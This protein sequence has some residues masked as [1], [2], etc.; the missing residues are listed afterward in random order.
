MHF[1]TFHAARMVC[2][3]GFIGASACAP[4]AFASMTLYG[5]VDSFLQYSNNSGDTAWRLQSGGASTSRWGI[6]GS[7]DLGGG[8]YS[9][10][11]LE[12]GIN[13]MNGQQQSATSIY[14]R[15]AN[16]WLGAQRFGTIKLGKQYPAIPPEGAD[17]FYAVGMLSPW[18][19]SVLAVSDLGPGAATVQARTDNAISYETPIWSGFSAKVLYALRNAAGASPVARNAGGIVN[20]ANGPLAFNVAYNAVWTDTP[21]GPAASTPDGPRTDI[22]MADVLYDFGALAASATYT[23]T[24]PT[25]PNTY[26]AAV[27]SLGAVWTH[28]PHVIRAGAVYRNVAGRE[29]SAFGALV[30]YDYQFSKLTGVYARVGGFR[31][32]GRSQLSF[33]SDPL[34]APGVNPFVVALGLRKKF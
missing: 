25:A 18:A 3:L 23:L 31:N 34:A 21:H 24:R 20:Y 12:S 19:S 26:V 9:G 27:Y 30:G 29:D 17:P 13:L 22:V 14:N 10:F 11:R 28:G 16:V 5:A 15:E 32:Q 8:V 1:T 33:G 7:E 4:S 2:A 6:T